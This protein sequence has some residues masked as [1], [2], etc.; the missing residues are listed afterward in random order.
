MK[1]GLPG[2]KTVNEG[3][4]RAYLLTPEDIEDD[5]ENEDEDERKTSIASN[6]RS[7]LGTPIFERCLSQSAAPPS[8][9]PRFPNRPRRRSRP[10]S[11]QLSL[12]S[13]SLDAED[14]ASKDA[15]P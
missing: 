12:V 15:V 4:K 9:C 1:S 6:P 13:C 14:R 8:S 10:P 7:L 2:E 5:D 3:S 11:L